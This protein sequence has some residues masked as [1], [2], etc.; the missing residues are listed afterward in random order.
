MYGLFNEVRQLVGSDD[1]LS[2]MKNRRIFNTR[3][4]G[5]TVTVRILREDF[6]NT[7][8][9]PI[10]SVGR[11]RGCRS[12]WIDEDFFIPMDVRMDIT[13]DTVLTRIY[14]GLHFTERVLLGLPIKVKSNY[15]KLIGGINYGTR[16]KITL[17]PR[18]S[19]KTFR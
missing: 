1:M 6:M 2:L 14:K 19:G 15:K 16:R 12:L 11:G 7:F 18:R 8:S 4:S 9:D 3:Q 5:K 13:L 17:I 10:G